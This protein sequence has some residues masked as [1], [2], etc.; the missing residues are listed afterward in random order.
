M[1]KCQTFWIWL[2][3]PAAVDA[4]VAST[5]D[6]R[7]SDHCVHISDSFGEEEEE[8]KSQ[9]KDTDQVKWLVCWTWHCWPA[10]NGHG[11]GKRTKALRGVAGL[12]GLVWRVSRA[13]RHHGNLA[14]PRFSVV[15]LQRVQ[16]Q[17]HGHTQA[18]THAHTHTQRVWC[19][20]FHRLSAPFCHFPF[21]ILLS[22]FWLMTAV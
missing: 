18:H 19:K 16:Y 4:G 11:V 12:E 3:H 20:E 2:L 8:E 21:N 9:Q 1:V 15:D 10:S 17:T 7:S 6:H 22:R 13:L 14:F 5:F